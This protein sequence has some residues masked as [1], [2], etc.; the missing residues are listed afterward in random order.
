MQAKRSCGWITQGDG[1]MNLK[2]RSSR[3]SVVLDNIFQSFENMKVIR[4]M[5]QSHGKSIEA[6]EILRIKLYQ[7]QFDW[8]QFRNVNKG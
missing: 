4:N 8:I 3:K 1:D 6:S 2:T 5:I 7:T